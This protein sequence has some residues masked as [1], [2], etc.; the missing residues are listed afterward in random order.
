MSHDSILILAADPESVGAR[1]FN[2]ADKALDYAIKWAPSVVG[3]LLLLV[4][5][6]IVAGWLRKFVVGALERAK[7]DTTLAR[8]FSNVARWLI[9]LLGFLAAAGTFGINITG[10]AAIIGAVGLAISLGFQGTLSNLASGVLL[11]VFRPFRVGD[12]VVVAGQAGTVDAIDLF[13]TTLDTAD[14]RRIIVPNG[15]IFGNIIENTTHHPRRRGEIRL[16]VAPDAD[17]ALVRRVLSEAVR[18]ALHTTPGGLLEPAPGI[19]LVEVTPPTWS[20][21]F[22]SQTPRMAEVREGVLAG[23]KGAMDVNALNPKPPAPVV[24]VR[25]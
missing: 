19:V 21:L 4:L 23:V 5:S 11:L 15:A 16:P 6:L 13:T 20:L 9:L 2:W 1:A 22:W 3:A 7:V 8:F 24:V 14:N 17:P 12:S 18:A 10:F 25:G